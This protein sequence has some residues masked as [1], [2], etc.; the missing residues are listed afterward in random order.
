[1][2][3]DK[4][5]RQ[6]DTRHEPA[7]S[8]QSSRHKSAVVVS[9]LKKRPGSP[10][11][12]KRGL[13]SGKLPQEPHQQF[14]GEFLSMEALPQVELDNAME[15][16]PTHVY[17]YMGRIAKLSKPNQGSMLISRCLWGHI[18]FLHQGSFH[19]FDIS[20]HPFTY[21]CFRKTFFPMSALAKQ[22]FTCVPQNNLI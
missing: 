3:T 19:M 10:T 20:K 18:Y 12:L 9:I 6:A 22:P 17:Q 11:S 21:V 1:V 8:V 7:A 2:A 5:S 14:F 15:G 16:E 13:R 4:S